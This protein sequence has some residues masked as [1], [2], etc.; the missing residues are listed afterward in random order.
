MI[1]LED[2]CTKLEDHLL[3]ALTK[4]GSKS[5]SQRSHSF[6]F[7]MASS[8]LKTHMFLSKR[9]KHVTSTGMEVILDDLRTTGSFNEWMNLI[10][11]CTR[12]DDRSLGA[13]H[14]PLDADVRTCANIEEVSEPRLGRTRNRGRAR[15]QK[16]FLVIFV[17]HKRFYTLFGSR[18]ECV[19]SQTARRPCGLSVFQNISLTVSWYRSEGRGAICLGLVGSVQSDIPTAILNTNFLNATVSC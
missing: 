13:H 16:W 14:L 12:K 2:Y 9:Q 3:V 11:S 4:T 8:D 6:H 1:V 5:E 10:S 7:P 18:T 17:V 19:S 15:N